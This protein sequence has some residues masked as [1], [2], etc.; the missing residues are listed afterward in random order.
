MKIKKA[1]ESIQLNG[2]NPLITENSLKGLQ[3]L[4]EDFIMELNKEITR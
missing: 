3:E 1:K 4:Q 2:V